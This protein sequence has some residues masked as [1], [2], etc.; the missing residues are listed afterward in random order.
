M[1]R[2]YLTSGIV[3]ALLCALGIHFLA[4]WIILDE[5]LQR[6]VV[7]LLSSDV[8]VKSKFGD[9]AGLTPRVTGS[10]VTKQSDGYAKGHFIY[11]IQGGLANGVIAVDWE[12]M[13]GEMIINIKHI[14]VT[15]Y[16]PR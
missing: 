2:K 12:R 11:A 3:T 4:R 14:E 13:P 6:D 15:D 7:D 5:S 10:R 1:K 8:V 9:L 16:K